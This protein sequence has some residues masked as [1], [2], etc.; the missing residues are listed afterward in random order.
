MVS[1]PSSRVAP[2]PTC[3][4]PAAGGGP[5]SAAVELTDAQGGSDPAFARLIR[6]H[7]RI[8]YSLALRALGN[9]A[10]AE[11]LAQ[12]VFLQL[13][14]DLERIESMDH[15][16]HWLRRTTS[17]RVIDR[18]RQRD[19][20]PSV[21]SLGDIECD[22][23]AL[24]PSGSAEGGDPLLARRLREHLAELDA[25][26]RLVLVLRFQED[27]DPGEIARVLDLPVN[28]VKSHLRRSLARL[29]VAMDEG[30]RA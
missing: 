20:R 1:I 3:T 15:L 16:A 28:T 6:A 5:E 19:R 25:I 9:A 23:V 12:D 27:L 7:Q 4:Q 22:A 2:E 24:D 18:L 11:E 13:Y 10:E 17:R 29:R 26:P 30:Q 8:V 14:R 21:T